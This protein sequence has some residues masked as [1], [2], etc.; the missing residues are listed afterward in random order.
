MPFVNKF[1]ILVCTAC[2]ML[3]GQGFAAWDGSIA[4]TAP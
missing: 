1:K 4:T 2:L 3:V